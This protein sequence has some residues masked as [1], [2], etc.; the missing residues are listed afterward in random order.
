M[1]K[2]DDI[3]PEAD[4]IGRPSMSQLDV[5]SNTLGVRLFHSTFT[6]PLQIMILMERE[7]IKD[8]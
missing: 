5:Y 7:I 6:R 8:E 2:R 3:I 1:H 4:K